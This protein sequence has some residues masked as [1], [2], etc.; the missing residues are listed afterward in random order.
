MSPALSASRPR[1]RRTTSEGGLSGEG[2]S[3]SSRVTG[4]DGDEGKILEASTSSPNLSKISEYPDSLDQRFHSHF[5]GTNPYRYLSTGSPPAS[6]ESFYEAVSTSSHPQGGMCTP[7]V[8]ASSSKT[9]LA[10]DGTPNPATPSST[11]V[12]AR[13]R[14]SRS[15]LSA[16]ADAVEA[17]EPLDERDLPPRPSTAHSTGAPSSHRSRTES[18]ASTTY[19]STRSSSR[20]SIFSRRNRH[21]AD[22]VAAPYDPDGGDETGATSVTE[23]EEDDDESAGQEDRSKPREAQGL[24][25]TLIIDTAHAGV[26]L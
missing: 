4:C 23:G 9:I 1:A 5:D 20:D 16:R 21:D 6:T 25:R 14:R 18:N 10:L 11:S 8:T 19:R 3:T 7:P 13:R 24:G 15:G 2:S 22:A 12:T 26:A 17:I